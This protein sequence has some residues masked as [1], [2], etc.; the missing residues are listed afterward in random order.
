MAELDTAKGT[1]TQSEDAFFLCWE[2]RAGHVQTQGKAFLTALGTADN[3]AISEQ[4]TLDSCRDPVILRFDSVV[5]GTVDDEGVCE[6]IAGGAG[7]GAGA[8]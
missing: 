6:S 2:R 4:S 3:Q 5:L 8:V 1:D 7:C